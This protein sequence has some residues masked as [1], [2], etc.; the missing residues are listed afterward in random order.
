[1]R[2]FF[3]VVVP[4]CCCFYQKVEMWTCPSSEEFLSA[5]KLRGVVFVPGACAEK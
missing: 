2:A 5:E 3:H 1:M 4:L